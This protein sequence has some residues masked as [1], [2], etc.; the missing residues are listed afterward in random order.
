MCNKCKVKIPDKYIQEKKAPLLS[1]ESTLKIHQ[2]RQ[3]TP[4]WSE[5][6]QTIDQK[7]K[8]LK[9]APNSKLAVLLDYNPFSETDQQLLKYRKQVIKQRTTPEQRKAILNQSKRVTDLQ[10]TVLNFK[11]GAESLALSPTSNIHYI[12]I[13]DKLAQFGTQKIPPQSKENISGDTEFLNTVERGSLTLNKRAAA[14]YYTEHYLPALIELNSPLRYSYQLSL[15]CASQLIHVED[16]LTSKYCKNRWCVVCNR[17]RT[18]GLIND[19]LPQIKAM[20]EKYFV[21]LTVRNCEAYQLKDY[22]K[23]YNLFWK[24]FYEIYRNRNKRTGNK[25]QAIKKIECTYNSQQDT[26]HP[27]LHAI[28]QGKETAE[29]LKKCWIVFCANMEKIEPNFVTLEYLNKI[30]PCNSRTVKELFKYFT[31]FAVKTGKKTKVVN[32]TQL[33]TVTKYRHEQ[34]FYVHAMDTMF[35]ALKGM[36]VFESCGIKKSKAEGKENE[37]KLS[38]EAVKVDK[39]ALVKT[40]YQWNGENW[41]HETTGN[42]ICAY[43]PGEFEINQRTKVIIVDSYDH[44]TQDNRH[45]KRRNLYEMAKKRNIDLT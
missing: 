1:A 34:A 9:N 29:L 40:K 14:K 8:A 35:T 20:K 6:I 23:L 44:Q 30:K 17:I 21:T 45:K 33:G 38:I 31:K 27:H 3:I 16:K 43:K 26:Y 28:I 11:T 36:R 37:E 42:N 4:E 18:A 5:A 13:L 39:A 24:Q 22:L 19:Y 12:Y 10:K 41:Q 25:L 7:N 2:G 15:E 32:H